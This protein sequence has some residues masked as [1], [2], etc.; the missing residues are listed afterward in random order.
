MLSQVKFTLDLLLMP[1]AFFLSRVQTLA[2][3]IFRRFQ[4]SDF[5]AVHKQCQS[6][7]FMPDVGPQNLHRSLAP[8][9]SSGTRT[10]IT[11]TMMSTYLP[12]P[13]TF[14]FRW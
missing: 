9:R 1:V 14:L 10:E 7:I 3:E 11:S 2:L 12:T 6:L 8:K 4:P 5:S 13:S